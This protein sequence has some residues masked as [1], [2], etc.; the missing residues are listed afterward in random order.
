MDK[1]SSILWRISN[2]HDDR[3]K[4]FFP[5]F[6]FG[7]SGNTTTNY[8]TGQGYNLQY[9]QMFHFTVASTAAAV[10]GFA[11]QYGGPLWLSQSNSLIEIELNTI[12]ASFRGLG[13]FSKWLSQV[14]SINE[15]TWT[16]VFVM[17]WGLSLAHLALL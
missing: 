15:C 1:D 4:S 13:S 6:Q 10:T 16:C 9:P 14:K 11:Q 8:S 7:Q 5:C 12:S 3:N 17:N 2:G